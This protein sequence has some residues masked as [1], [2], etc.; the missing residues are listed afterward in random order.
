MKTYIILL[1]A[2]FLAL[3]PAPALSQQYTCDDVDGLPVSYN[4]KVLISNPTDETT[5]ADLNFL[6]LDTLI[7]ESSTQHVLHPGETKEQIVAFLVSPTFRGCSHLYRG[8]GVKVTLTQQILTGA[9]ATKKNEYFLPVI[10]TPICYDFVGSP[11]K[12]FGYNN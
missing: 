3:I 12:C 8:V 4:D 5:W 6:N 11:V 10:E 7:T 9:G 1:V 2:L